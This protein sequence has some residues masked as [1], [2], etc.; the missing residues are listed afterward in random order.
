MYKFTLLLND[1][2]L[3]MIETELGGGTYPMKYKVI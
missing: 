1:E 2:Q 3:K